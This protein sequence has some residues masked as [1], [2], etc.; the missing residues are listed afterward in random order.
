MQ[1]LSLKCPLVPQ[2]WAPC[3]FKLEGA[4]DAHSGASL[5]QP[6]TCDDYDDDDDDDDW[7]VWM[8]ISEDFNDSWTERE[9]ARER[10]EIV[11]R[12]CIEINKK[13]FCV[14]ET[15]ASAV[16]VIPMQE[17]R[18]DLCWTLVALLTV[19]EALGH[20]ARY[21]MTVL[22]KGKRPDCCWLSKICHGP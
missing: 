7:W 15:P 21:P 20:R 13:L 8:N 17:T 12:V 19:G 3:P 11:L 10:E 14:S 2:I 16:M 4:M 6:L 9:R 5:E 18:R 1:N 22:G